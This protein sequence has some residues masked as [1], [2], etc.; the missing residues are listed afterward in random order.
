MRNIHRD[1][2]DVSVSFHL[3]HSDEVE[4]EEEVIIA[5]KYKA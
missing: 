5:S 1:S 3:S 4:V 2:S